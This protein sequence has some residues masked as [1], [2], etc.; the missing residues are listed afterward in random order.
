MTERPKRLLE[1]GAS[2]FERELLAASRLDRGSPRALAR[3]HGAV[4]L[5]AAG[6]TASAVTSTASGSAATGALLGV[7]KWLGIGAVSGTVFASGMGALIEGSDPKPA[8]VAAQ[9]RSP[10]GTASGT[11]QPRATAGGVQP[12]APEIPP[13]ARARASSALLATS[14]EPAPAL[15]TETAATQLAEE[16]RLIGDATRLERAGDALGALQALDSYARRFPQGTL[17][18]EAAVVRVRALVRA[19]RK[20][21]AQAIARS[22]GALNSAHGRAMK[23]ALE[24]NVAKP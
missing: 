10:A 8:R 20:A 24:G 16:T 1:E 15:P 3:T 9:P 18:P 5:I 21:E 11:A 13:P 4:R 17:G 6:L 12:A 22:A 7:V 2:D 23:N 14:D 19:G